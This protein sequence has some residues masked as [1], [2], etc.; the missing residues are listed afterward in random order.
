MFVSGLSVGCNNRLASCYFAMLRMLMTRSGAWRSKAMP[1]F[2]EVTAI[3]SAFALAGVSIALLG[4]KGWE[5][6]DRGAALGAACVILYKRLA[7][8][9]A[10]HL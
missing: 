4:G 7:P 3:T 5:A 2:T 10:S 1:G 6:A 8:I 9:A